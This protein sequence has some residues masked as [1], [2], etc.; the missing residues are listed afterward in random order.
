MPHRSA[1]RADPVKMHLRGPGTE[2]I[3]T[4]VDAPGTLAIRSR[5]PRPSSTEISLSTATYIQLSHKENESRTLLGQPEKEVSAGFLDS[6]DPPE[7]RFP[8]ARARVTGWRVRARQRKV[9]RGR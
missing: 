6:G 3:G 5:I 4:R 1:A 2:E 7:R 8:F 9:N